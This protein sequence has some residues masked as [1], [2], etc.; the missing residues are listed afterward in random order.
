MSSEEE[1]P[2]RE[3]LANRLLADPVPQGRLKVA[4][5]VSPGFIRNKSISPAGTAD[6]FTGC[7]PGVVG[8]WRNV[9]VSR[10]D[11]LH[12]FS[13]PY[14]T[15]PGLFPTTQHYVLGYFQ[16]SLRDWSR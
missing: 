4:Q 6:S 13:R 12:Y 1:A 5:D 11:V 3:A 8:L 15:D 9:R 16:P 10:T 14:G 2:A 7:N